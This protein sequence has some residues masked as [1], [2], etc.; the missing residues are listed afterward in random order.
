VGEHIGFM[1]LPTSPPV[2]P[3][4]DM[5]RHGRSCDR[6]IGP[7][8]TERSPGGFGSG[9][10]SIRSLRATG[11]FSVRHARLNAFAPQWGAKLSHLP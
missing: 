7:L 11:H 2:P 5:G 8:K 4:D 1:P 10:P 6:R 3:A 9:L